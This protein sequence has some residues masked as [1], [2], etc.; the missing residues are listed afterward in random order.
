MKFSRRSR[1]KNGKKGMVHVQRGIVHVHIKPF[2]FLMT[3][4]RCRRCG[5]ILR[6]QDILRLQY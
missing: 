1:E 2:A 5:R 4:S 6:N 3:F